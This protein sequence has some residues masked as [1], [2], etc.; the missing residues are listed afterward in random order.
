MKNQKLNL[1]KSTNYK[2]V[3]GALPGVDLWLKTCM[4]PT[5]SANEVPVPH[6][7]LGNE[8]IPSN[9]MVW[10]PLMVTFLVDEDLEN[11]NSVFEWMAK[12]AGPNLEDREAL[13]NLQTTASLHI[14]SNN[15]NTTG[16]KYTF[17]NSF[18]IILGELQFNNETA[19]EL[20]TDITLQF[21]YMT[22]DR[23]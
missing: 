15:K 20:L 3:L 16:L 7:F 2:L 10:A 13:E 22:I 19:E 5:I 18:P 6:P 21:D 1:A 4:L 14:L 23:S 17:H 11:Y 8:Y 12:A 9:T